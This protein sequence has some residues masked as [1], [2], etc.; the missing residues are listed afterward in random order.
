MPPVNPVETKAIL[1]LTAIASTLL[2]I[3]GWIAA[4]M[5]VALVSLSIWVAGK[6]LRRVR[7]GAKMKPCN[8]SRQIFQSRKV[9]RLP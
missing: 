2:S 7:G 3:V 5:L 8:P 4:L 9:T 6:I 1:E